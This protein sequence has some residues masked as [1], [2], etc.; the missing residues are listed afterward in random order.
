[1]RKFRHFL[2][3]GPFLGAAVALRL[4]LKDGGNMVDF[5]VFLPGGIVF[6]LIVAVL[7]S[8]MTQ[9]GESLGFW[10]TPDPAAPVPRPRWIRMSLIGAGAFVILVSVAAY[11]V[12]A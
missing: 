7:V 1:M 12:S 6:G 3:M 5:L 9:A 2:I 10:T 4:T 11:F 8:L